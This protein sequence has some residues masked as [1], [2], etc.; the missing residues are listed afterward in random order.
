MPLASCRSV[1]AVAALLC[2]AAAAAQPLPL[3]TT[4]DDFLLPGTQPETVVHEFAT[5]DQCTGCHSN[6]G[7]PAVEPFR[8]WQGSMMAQAGRDPLNWAAIAIA[9]QDAAGSGETCIRCHMPK[10]WLE[11]R[12]AAADGTLITAADRHG[13]QCSV[14]HRLVDPNAGPGAPAE[15]AAILAALVEP[16]PMPA[17][18]MMVVDP[19]DR[20]RGP[21]NVV[22]D[23]GGDP[24][25]P[26]ASTLVSPYH[27]SSELCGTCHNVRNAV[28]TK[29]ALTGRFEPNPFDT[30]GDPA[31]GFPEQTTFDEWAASEY[32]AAGVHAPQFGRNQAVVSSCQDCHMPQ[33]SGR[34]ATTGLRRD[35]LP[36]HDMTGANTF[37]PKIIP[38]HPVF[39]PEVDPALLDAGVVRATDMLRRAATLSLALADGELRVRVTNESGHKLPTGYPEGRRMWLEVRAFDRSRRVVYES[40]RYVFDT[41]TLVEDA[42][43]KLWETRHGLDE[44][45]AAQVALPAG[46]SFHLVLNN[47]VL[48]DN[49]IPPRGFSNAAF[50]AFDGAPVG[51]SYADGQYWDEVGYPV[52]SGAV[53]AEATLWYQT[54]SREYVEFLRDANTTNAAGFV[55][56][57]LWDAHGRSEPVAM[58]RGYVEEKA[59]FAESCRKNVAKQ[60][61]RYR[62]AHE[63]EWS[64]CFETEGDGL[65]CDDAERDAKL[66]AAD[67]ALRDGL[68]G[69]KDKKCAGA[70][71]TPLSLGHGTSCPQPCASITLFEIDDLADCSVCLADA[72]D[73][74]ALEAAWGA[75]PPE[76]PDKTPASA[77]SCQEHLAKAAQG[78]AAG[79]TKA[80]AKCERKSAGQD[81]PADCA[82]DP[83]VAKA[84]DKA[85]REIEGCTSFSGLSGC[86]EAGD[87]DGVL[88]CMSEAL[89]VPATGYVGASY[90]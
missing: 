52:G 19:L 28:F 20:R 63:K 37:V 57:D 85:R 36:L 51:A 25:L 2:A 14:C 69:A 71:R 68:G 43:L 75:A 13:V 50:E 9:N 77:A 73:G 59:G 65:S 46:K 15:D 5:P 29:N 11:G 89:E 26:A 30:P 40:G 53:A 1:L 55:L 84:Q 18:A 35:D 83:G 64:R 76:L 54:A 7:E 16:V 32:A 42:D 48:F 34:D 87:V 90:P 47:V 23:L 67:A 62:K 4:H 38:H 17:N 12:S 66:A 58:A 49:R 60:Q 39:G 56:F 45:F 72:L 10:G 79:W 6:Y 33:V 22:A 44:E 86:A 81:P 74:A 21:F 8:N 88:A 61:D 78:L 41:A 70:N 80:L 3:P 27:L 82:A 31:A 24:H